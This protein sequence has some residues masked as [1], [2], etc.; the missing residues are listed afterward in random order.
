MRTSKPSVAKFQ[1]HML[2]PKAGIL[3]RPLPLILKLEHNTQAST[4]QTPPLVTLRKC[5]VTLQ[6]NTYIQCIRDEILR[7]GDEQRDWSADSHI[8][9]VDYSAEMDKAPPVTE[10]MD[11]QRLMR[12]KIPW[13]HKPTFSTFNIRRTYRF[14]HFRCIFPIS[15][16]IPEIY[17][18]TQLHGFEKQY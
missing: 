5:I 16:L 12:I 1:L 17:P 7:E 14:V 8:A 3:A 2:L 9:S 13:H 15:P 4:T 18:I 6:A 10:S 11:L